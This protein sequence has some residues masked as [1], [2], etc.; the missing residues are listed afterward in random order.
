MLNNA[1]PLFLPGIELKLMNIH[2]YIPSMNIHEHSN[3]VIGQLLLAEWRIISPSIYKAVNIFRYPFLG[4]TAHALLCYLPPGHYCAC[5]PMHNKICFF[6]RAAQ[7]QTARCAS[8]RHVR[9]AHKL[10]ADSTG[11]SHRLA[12]VL[13][14]NHVS[15][16]IFFVNKH[17]GLR[18][19]SSWMCYTG[20]MI[21]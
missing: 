8:S 20:Q 1:T 3:N 9:T 16:R 2:F 17:C 18:S 19:C 5:S 21:S 4:S 13:D 11:A 12:P 10:A 14:S 6:Q 15:G 7:L